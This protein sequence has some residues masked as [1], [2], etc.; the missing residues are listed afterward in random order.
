MCVCVCVCICICVW[1]LV[2]N[3]W[4]SPEKKNINTQRGDI[5]VWGFFPGAGITEF[6]LL[7]FAGFSTPMHCYST[8]HQS[9][10]TVF[11]LG[12]WCFGNTPVNS[13]TTHPLKVAA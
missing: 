7:F 11:S 3:H 1:R 8:N 13:S 9:P 2:E 4:L 5:M 10:A 12:L 6:F